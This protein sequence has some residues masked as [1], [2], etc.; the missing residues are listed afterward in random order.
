MRSEDN[1][2]TWMPAGRFEHPT[3]G[4]FTTE[5]FVPEENEVHAFLQT[6]DS[7]RWFSHNQMFRAI[8]RDGGKNW[9]APQSVAGGVPPGWMNVGI[10]HSSR[11]WVLPLTWPEFIGQEWGE[12]VSGRAP[13]E[14]WCGTRRLPTLEL[15]RDV[16]SWV[17]YAEGNAW[18]HRNHRYTAGVLI[19]AD[20]GETFQLR[21]YLRGGVENHLMEPQLVELS[22]GSIVMLLRSMNEGVLL[23]AV[24]ND[25]G[26]TWSALERTEIPNP[27]SKVNILRHSD[28]RIFLLH[29]P[30]RDT[31]NQMAMRSP[32]SLW[33]SHDDM[34]TWAIKIDLVRKKE[35]AKH[36]LNYPS[37]FLDEEADVLR[38]V[39]E[40][41]HSVFFMSVPLDM[42]SEAK[43]QSF[44]PLEEA[45]L[46][47]PKRV[48]DSFLAA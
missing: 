17:R 13:G 5:L 38:F 43:C 19:S 11:R 36:G 3:R 32:L 25:G 12:P 35:P 14:A 23:R 8:S 20:D 47:T 40:D 44:V 9:T 24:S 31:S 34:A 37:G 2:I 30:S 7:G 45:P 41:S 28:G 21:G 29:N 33:V 15:P 26:E 6:Y 18:C 46:V 42:T 1:G 27:S 48:T 10:R 22:D 39:W 16:E 4:L